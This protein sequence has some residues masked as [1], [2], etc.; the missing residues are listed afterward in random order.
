MLKNQTP[1]LPSALKIKMTPSMG[2]IEVRV[3]VNDS[4]AIVNVK[5]PMVEGEWI[6]KLKEFQG[7]GTLEAN[8]YLRLIETYF[9]KTYKELWGKGEVTAALLINSFQQAYP[10]Y[11]SVSEKQKQL[12]KSKQHLLNEIEELMRNKPTKY[13]DRLEVHNKKLAYLNKELSITEGRERRI[14]NVHVESRDIKSISARKLLGKGIF[15][16]YQLRRSRLNE[17]GMCP[18]DCR[19]RINGITGTAFSTR[20]MVDPANWS[21]KFQCIN[22]NE[23]DTAKLNT[24]KQGIISVYEEFRRRGKIPTPQIVIAHYFDNSLEYDKRLTLDEVSHLYLRELK[25][26][27]R[28]PATLSRYE[29]IHNYFL[30]HS[31]LKYADDVRVVHIKSFWNWMRNLQ[32]YSQDYSNKSVQCLY[33]LF[34]KAIECQV[35]DKNPIKG[36]RL[37]WEN[38]LDLTCLDEE[39]LQKLKDTDWSPKLQNVVDSFLFMCYTGLHIS[40][41]DNLTDANIKSN[42]KIKW[43]EYDRKK[44]GKPAIIPLHPV[45]SGI[46]RKYGS[47]AKLPRI[48]GQK[49]NDYLK[50]VAERIGSEKHL[51]NKVARKTFTDMSINQRG[52]SFEAV[53]GMLGHSSTK[54]VKVYGKVRHQRI[55]NEWKA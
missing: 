5:M 42:M 15:V 22:G 24:I 8:N 34:E 45:A 52:M 46:I 14:N 40:D 10:Q 31:Q 33:G 55:L 50:I 6:A 21:S 19:V 11:L 26:K 3:S 44:T 20:I 30:K 4:K 35:I 25:A 27:G 54:F 12:L 41:Y 43:V 9:L 37:D 13:K 32:G 49:Q 36:I 7:D 28:T 23:A 16:R 48:S 38:K 47:I 53:A 51:T 18:I 39:E 2:E 1:A 17:H 29:R